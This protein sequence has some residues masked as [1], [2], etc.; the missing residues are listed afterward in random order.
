VKV[1]DKDF[2]NFW[3]LMEHVDKFEISLP[4]EHVFH[5]TYHSHNGKV[6]FKNPDTNQ[7][8]ELSKENFKKIFG[9]HSE[10]LL[11]YMNDKKKPSLH[12]DELYIASIIRYYFEWIV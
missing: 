7:E 8:G 10:I 3:R 11:S 12:T 6:G 4:Y 2:D 5:I 1:S 9:K